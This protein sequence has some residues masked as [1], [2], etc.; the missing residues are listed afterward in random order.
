[1]N[2]FSFSLIK[3]LFGLTTICATPLF[4]A[5]SSSATTPTDQDK[6]CTSSDN[7]IDISR[8]SEAFGHLIGK[9]MENLGLKFDLSGVV[10][11]LQ[12]AAAGKASPMTEVECV[13]A[14]TTI[15]ESLF[16][17]QAEK[18]LQLA[19]SFMAKNANE[20]GIVKVENGKL[21]YKVEH[22][23]NGDEVQE[24]FSPLIRYVGKF[25][26]GSVFGA[27]KEEEVISLDE[28]IPGITKGLVGMK[29]GEKRILYIHPDMGYGT[30]SPL[31]P[32]SLLTF[33][34]EVVKANSTESE[35]QDS[36]T[37]TAN[38]NKTSSEL[39]SPSDSTETIR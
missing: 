33:E 23:G 18:N 9:N 1:M 22:N 26:D 6:E 3:Y 21:H 10:K 37:S 16:K 20:T 35:E 29:E 38:K 24:N 32:N 36:L 17:Q 13:Q 14:I 31:P 34:I 15:Q 5:D 39:A 25:L 4:A 11:G 30:S 8:L 7:N 28:T 12:D 2:H 27:S 19:N